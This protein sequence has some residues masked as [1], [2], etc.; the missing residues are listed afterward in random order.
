[1]SNCPPITVNDISR[2]QYQALL[3]TAQAQG[4]AL[5]GDAG[6]TTYQGMDFTWSYDA[7]AQL[8]TIQ[9]TEKPMFVPCSMI[10]TRIRGLIG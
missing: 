1:M 3:T 2:E 7:P 4:L 6:S 10:E 5:T 8:L 9:C